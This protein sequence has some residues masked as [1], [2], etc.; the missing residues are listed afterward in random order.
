VVGCSLLECRK[1]LGRRGVEDFSRGDF[2]GGMPFPLGPPPTVTCQWLL[3]IC[4][5]RDRS[6]NGGLAPHSC[7]ALLFVD[8]CR[9]SGLLGMT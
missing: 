4:R 9:R 7:D 3:Q 6:E 1:E 2:E 8:G 5:R